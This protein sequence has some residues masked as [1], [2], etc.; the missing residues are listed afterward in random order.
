MTDYETPTP[1]QR[2]YVIRIPLDLETLLHI[3]CAKL[4]LKGLL[5]LTLK[6]TDYETGKLLDSETLLRRDC[7]RQK[8]RLKQKGL[9]KLTLKPTDYEIVKLLDSE[10]L[11][12]KHCAKLRLK[13]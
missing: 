12:H 10:T 4:R 2:N 6:P 7:A 13:G 5:K 3:H 11:L 9:L 1:I 8:L